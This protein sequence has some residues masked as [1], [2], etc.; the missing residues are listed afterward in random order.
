MKKCLFLGLMFIASSLAFSAPA[1]MSSTVSKAVESSSF[2]YCFPDG[3]DC[4]M[5]PR[6]ALKLMEEKLQSKYP[7][8]IS[9][10]NY[11]LVN[12]FDVGEAAAKEYDFYVIVHEM[13]GLRYL[14]VPQVVRISIEPSGE[15]KIT[16]LS[17][18]A[19]IEEQYFSDPDIQAHM[20]NL[21]RQLGASRGCLSLLLS[22]VPIYLIK[23]IEKENSR[24]NIEREHSSY[25]VHL[26]FV[27][28]SSGYRLILDNDG[29]CVLH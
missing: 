18:I 15:M 12:V 28:A 10:Q 14:L 19:P 3:N 22:R 25:K 24:Y 27:V 26:S 20:K 29:R 5:I 1:D 23:N 2:S 11:G 17:R 13:D 9:Y 6:T 7:G 4:V 16:F 21:Y 8:T